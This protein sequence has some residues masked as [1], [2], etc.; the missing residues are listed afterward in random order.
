MMTDNSDT[1]FSF[2]RHGEIE[3]FNGMYFT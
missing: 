3:I 1:V 2:G